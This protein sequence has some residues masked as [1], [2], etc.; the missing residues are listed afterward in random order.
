M[1]RWSEV[2]RWERWEKVNWHGQRAGNVMRWQFGR[3]GRVVSKEGGMEL[4]IKSCCVGPVKRNVS[5]DSLQG[6]DNR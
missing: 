5:R 4:I 6:F 3:G 1:Y 2:A